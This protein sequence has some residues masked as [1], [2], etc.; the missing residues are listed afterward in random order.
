LYRRIDDKFRLEYA[1]LWQAL[2]YGDAVAI[3]QHAEAMNAGDMYPLFVAM[4][5]QVWW[6]TMLP[7]KNAFRLRA[8]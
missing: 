1:K 4:L 3:K 8:R 2:I 7:C 6:K 5:T